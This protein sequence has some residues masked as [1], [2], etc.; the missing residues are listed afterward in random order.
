[1]DNQGMDIKNES[2]DYTLVQISATR[3]ATA[4]LKEKRCANVV[5]LGVL[6]RALELFAEEA[7]EKA[8]RATIRKSA[9]LNVQAYHFGK[10]TFAGISTA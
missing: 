1:M 8:I 10:D 5:M 4:Q 7:V 2:F 6:N 9:D 3:L